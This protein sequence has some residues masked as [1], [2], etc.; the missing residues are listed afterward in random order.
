MNKDF[1]GKEAYNK[2]AVLDMIYTWMLY[3]SS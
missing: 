3:K 1:H 2:E